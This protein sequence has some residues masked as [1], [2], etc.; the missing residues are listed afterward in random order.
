MKQ[1]HFLAEILGTLWLLM[2]TTLLSARSTRPPSVEV[3]YGRS[4]NFSDQW[5][6]CLLEH[7]FTTATLLFQGVA[8]RAGTGLGASDV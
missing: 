2:E 8:L 6:H 1:N 4:P 3:I 5:T 7:P